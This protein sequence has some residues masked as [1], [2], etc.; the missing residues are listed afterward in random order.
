MPCPPATVIRTCP[1]T[2]RRAGQL[3]TV[4]TGVDPH[5]DSHTAVAIE[6]TEEQLGRRGRAG[7]YAEAAAPRAAASPLRGSA[8]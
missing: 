7:G 6:A 5:K 1:D 3:A 4:V 8:P 2:G